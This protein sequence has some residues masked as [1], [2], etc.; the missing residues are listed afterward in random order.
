MYATL[1]HPG[2]L[3]LDGQALHSLNESSAP[4]DLRGVGRHLTWFVE[5]G[6]IKEPEL[7][8]FPDLD[9]VEVV[10]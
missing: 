9:V 3:R 1:R 6:L 2:P 10:V 5:A 8:R 4:E 7:G